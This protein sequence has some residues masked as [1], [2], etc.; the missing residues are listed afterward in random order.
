[1]LSGAV[2]SMEDRDRCPLTQLLLDVRHSGALISS[3]L[4]PPRGGLLG[5]RSCRSACRVVLGEFDVEHL[6]RRCWRTSEQA[7]LAFH[8]TSSGQRADVA[9]P[10]TRRC[11]GDHGHQVAAG[12]VL[13]LRVGRIGHDGVT[14]GDYAGKRA[15]CQRQ[16]ALV[17]RSWSGTT[18]NLARVGLRCIRGRRR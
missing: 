17:G 16:V 12:G 14:G 4:M 2:L 13:L 9:R 11:V 10:S 15:I 3:R 1:M 6:T 7:A 5:R 8:A 18:G